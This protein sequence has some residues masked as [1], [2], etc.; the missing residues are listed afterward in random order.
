VKTRIR[1]TGDETRETVLRYRSVQARVGF[2]VSSLAHYPNASG[3]FVT[4]TIVVKA[5]Q[6]ALDVLEVTNEQTLCLTVSEQSLILGGGQV[7]IVVKASTMGFEGDIAHSIQSL[8][9]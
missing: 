8:E 2:S 3:T 4:A 7:E 5:R 1:L 9:A 6:V